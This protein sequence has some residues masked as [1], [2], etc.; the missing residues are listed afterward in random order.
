MSNRSFVDT[1]SASAAF[2]EPVV[3][4]RPV[5]L[6]D[7][8]AKRSSFIFYEG[9]PLFYLQVHSQKRP[10]SLTEGSGWLAFVHP[11]N[12]VDIWE[13]GL[14]ATQLKLYAGGSK[15]ALLKKVSKEICAIASTVGPKMRVLFDVPSAKENNPSPPLG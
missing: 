9:E 6:N 15:D 11:T 1:L 5:T 3:K 10:I 14:W 8:W 4:D 2:K 13:V 7:L 12:E